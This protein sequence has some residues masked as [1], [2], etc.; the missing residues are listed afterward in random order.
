ML[1]KKI[2]IGCDHAGF[3]H[4]E[5]IKQF[6]KGSGF[7]VIDFG[8]F[9]L[10]SVDYPDYGHKVAEVVEDGVVDRGILVCGSGNGINM[11]ANKHAGIRS[12][13]C[14]NEEVTRLARQHNDANILALPAR[15]IS[16]NEAKQF[17]KIFLE[18]KF[19]GGRHLKRLHKLPKR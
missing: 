10:D 19:E 18:E 6:L 11:V 7:E 9:S 14:W 17:V 4:K 15:F 3:E 2:A 16:E 13:L 8:T 5:V 12:A 1:I